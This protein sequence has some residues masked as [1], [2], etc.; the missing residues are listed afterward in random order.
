VNVRRSSPL[1]LALLALLGPLFALSVTLHAVRAVEGR[2]AWLPVQVQAGPEGYPVV[3]GFAVGTGGGAPGLAVGD[4]LLRVGERDLR[5]VGALGFTPQAWA[6]LGPDLGADLVWRRG[7]EEQRGTLTLEPVPFPL[8]TLPLTILTGLIAILVL[9]RGRGSAAARAFYLAGVSHSLQWS[10]FFGPVPWQSALSLAVAI[11]GATLTFPLLLRA[12]MK[13]PA[14]PQPQSVAGRAW[15]WLFLAMGPAVTSWLLGWPLPSALG[16]PAILGLNVALGVCA[17]AIVTRSFR[18]SGAAGRRKL[19]WV[20]YGFYLA[21]LPL[22][23]AAI[24]AAGDPSLTWVYEVAA[25]GAVAIPICGCIAFVRDDFLDID[26]LITETTAYTGASLLLIAVLLQVIPTAARAV[27]GV[28]GI[29]DGAAQALVLGSLAGVAVPARRW[30]SPLVEAA[31]FRERGAIERALAALR[32]ELGALAE[33]GALLARLGERLTAILEPEGCA[34]YA[35]GEAAFGPVFASGLAAPPSFAADGALVALL[36]DQTGP[37]EAA[38]WRG[39]RRS[40][41][42]AGEPGAALEALQPALLVPVRGAER[43][44]AFVCLGPKHSG[45][46]YAASE[47][48]WLTAVA[49]RAASQLR[50]SSDAELLGHAREL[51]ERL[52]RYVPGAVAEGIERGEELAPREREVSLFFVDIRG[53]T[54]FA[55]TRSPEEIFATVSL[56]T[57]TV[58]RLVG[59][60]GGAVVEFHGDGLMAVFGAPHALPAKERA[61]LRAAREVARAVPRLPV[62]GAPL[63][64]GVGI[65]TGPAFVG[66]IQSADRVIWGALGNTTNLAARLQAM[67]RELSAAVVIDAPTWQRGGDG[68]AGFVDQGELPIRGRSDP[69]RVYALPLGRSGTESTNQ[70]TPPTGR[71]S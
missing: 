1:D 55:E 41:L 23:A 68:A 14:A 36:D 4:T 67:S 64:V 8:R 18:R 20:V 65:A 38:R 9:L 39:W 66:N 47:V 53:Y 11:G 40:G 54:S 49:E 59:E 56:Y 35:R 13:I 58:S 10:T 44:A 45:E 21:L 63:S 61:A 57:D 17:L 48:A 7:G 27:A 31:F 28:V 24:L 6:A 2:I 69:E 5:G 15:P 30:L 70:L 71:L 26:R 32:D 3:R 43:I 16:L 34:I 25:A 19:K 51:R 42:L 46:L 22:L 12:L 52:A 50:R 33:P 62:A 60:Q 37:V 29:N